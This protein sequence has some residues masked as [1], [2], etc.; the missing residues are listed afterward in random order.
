[1]EH[2]V[3]L[4]KKALIITDLQ[5]KY[6]DYSSEYVKRINFLV[7][8][9]RKRDELV[10]WTMFHGQD[11]EIDLFGQRAPIRGE[12]GFEIYQEFEVKE[13]DIV[14]EKPGYSN[15]SSPE[16]E[17]VLKKNDV[18]TIVLVG[19]STGV[20]VLATAYDALH[21]GFKVRTVKDALIGGSAETNDEGLKLLLAYGAK[22]FEY[23]AQLS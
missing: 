19:R 22:E 18:D 13:S 20:C 10:V 5:A 4:D 1:M 6:T 21:R 11:W 9:F 15:F 8:E 2:V 3:Y 23:S 7:R 16:F 12:V 17:K 14:I